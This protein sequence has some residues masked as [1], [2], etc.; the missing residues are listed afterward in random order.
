MFHY[1]YRI[2]IANTDLY[3]FGKRSSKIDIKK[4]RYTGSGTKLL[5]F[6]GSQRIKTIISEHS[7]SEEAFSAEK[8]IIGDLWKTDPNCLNQKPGG[9]GAPSGEDHHWFNKPSTYCKSGQEHHAFGKERSEEVCKR[10]SEGQQLR[11]KSTYLSGENH[12]GFGKERSIETKQK[13]SAKNKGKII[14]PFSEDHKAKISLGLSGYKKSKEHQ[15][16]IGEALKGKTRPKEV[17]DKIA[18]ANTGKIRP[19][20]AIQRTAEANR[21]RKNLRLSC[22]CCRRETD[23]SNFNR[24]HRQC[25]IDLS[26]KIYLKLP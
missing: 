23:T 11:D 19:L 1:I 5:T 7:S 22:L 6:P 25:F 13:L 3:Y 10:I 12:P 4:D 8:I 24:W 14:G 15:Q 2:D 20:D 17:V 21:G 9:K 16:K 18:F 26:S